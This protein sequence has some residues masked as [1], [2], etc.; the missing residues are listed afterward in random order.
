MVG[1]VIFPSL[2]SV[3]ALLIFYRRVDDSANN[4]D[5]SGTFSVTW[6]TISKTP[7]V[8]I[9]T[10]IPGG[11]YNAATAVNTCEAVLAR[12]YAATEATSGKMV[13]SYEIG[14]GSIGMRCAFS[15][16]FYIPFL[17]VF[18][19][20]K[21]SRHIVSINILDAL[22]SLQQMVEVCATGLLLMLNS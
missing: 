18:S 3:K 6:Y 7:S 17:L 20:P 9:A 15:I 1:I 21:V 4:G 13:P 14:V 19:P 8:Y 12:I 11:K 2:D 5:V 10:N 22:V 16:Y